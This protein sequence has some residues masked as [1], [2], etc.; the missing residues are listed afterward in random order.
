[1][2]ILTYLV[3]A[4]QA[5]AALVTAAN[6]VLRSILGAVLPLT[7]LQLYDQLGLG[8]GNSL[9]GLI[10]LVLAPVSWILAKF[11]QRIRMNSKLSKAF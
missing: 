8:R 9:L 1:M 5:H 7:R 4:Y 11:G 2:S 10:L 3:D 6:A